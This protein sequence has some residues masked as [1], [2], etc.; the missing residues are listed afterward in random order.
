MLANV[1]AYFP[2]TLH[3]A[4]KKLDL[5]RDQFT[6]FVICPVCESLYTFKQC[7]TTNPVTKAKTPKLCSHV[8]YPNHLQISRRNPCGHA[9]LREV[10]LK[11]GKKALYPLKVYCYKSLLDS[12]PEI[13][14]REGMLDKCEE[15]RCRKVPEGYLGDMYDGLV[16]QEFYEVNGKP[17]LA[18]QNN[19][20]L[21][22]NC[23]WFQPFKLTEYSVGVIYAVIINLPR[24]IRF[25]HE[26]VIIV[27]IIPGPSEP[28]LHLN[29]Y[30]R[31]LV[32]D[33]LNLWRVGVHVH[34][35][36]VKAALLCNIACDLPAA[37]KLCGFLSH[38]SHHG[39]SRC[40]QFFPYDA[41]RKKMDY[42]G[43]SQ[44]EP[45]LQ[46]EHKSNGIKWSMA[47]SKSAREDI[48]KLTGSRYTKLNLLPYFN[49]VRFTVIDPMH[50][51]FLGTSKHMMKKIWLKDGL[52]SQNDMDRIHNIIKETLIPSS[53]GR[54]PRKILSSYSGF[55]ADQ[56]KNW[57][58]LFS[59]VC[60]HSVLP[61]EHIECWRVF[62]EICLIIS[63]PLISL[64][65]V[66]KI[67]TLA[68]KFGTKFQ[69]LY[70][71]HRVTPNMH[72][73][74]H[75]SECILDFGPVYSFWLYSFERY[76][77][78]LGNYTTNQK[79]VEIQIMRKFLNEMH[80]K[81][82]ALSAIEQDNIEIFSPFFAERSKGS[83]YY[84]LAVFSLAFSTFIANNNYIFVFE[85]YC[86]R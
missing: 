50:N 44:H 37:H 71:N 76:N 21:M 19:V 65:D 84:R 3:M 26:N 45:R 67:A 16:W 12:I 28:S 27:G 20:G 63:T 60:L 5:N 39:C 68:T 30:L 6:K 75:L 49:C 59:L 25:K 17:F 11:D 61:Y 38:S 34:S 46:S 18:Q 58:S 24:A 41:E 83:C 4:K 33:L 31:P 66:A 52:I 10:I 47:D 73:H 86:S 48:E 7:Y 81:S 82:L 1:L 74:Q 9:L 2:T 85:P 32:D 51:L 23:D 53:I 79:S 14:G 8:E 77:G 62:V 80:I 72:L 36:V 40:K 56:W 42:S 69:E 43:F 78:I 70:G 54:L 35:K 29:S 57:T 22:L 15:W 13:L 55:T 64:D